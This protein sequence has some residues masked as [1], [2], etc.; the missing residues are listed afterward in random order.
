MMLRRN[1][2]MEHT[3]MSH[4]NPLHDMAGLVMGRCCPA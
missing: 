2:K 1:R 4:D 3:N